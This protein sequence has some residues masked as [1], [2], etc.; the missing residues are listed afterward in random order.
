[1]DVLT[2]LLSTLLARGRHSC[3]E[4][5]LDANDNPKYVNEKDSA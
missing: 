4:G 2:N 1:M 3:P 5:L